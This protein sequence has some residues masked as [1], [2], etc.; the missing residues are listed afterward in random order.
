MHHTD[1]CHTHTSLM[2]KQGI[3]LKVDLAGFG[4]L[5]N[6][7][8]VNFANLRDP[9]VTERIIVTSPNQTSN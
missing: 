3:H 7:I 9:D 2:P 6:I 4:S 5:K 8:K 1:A